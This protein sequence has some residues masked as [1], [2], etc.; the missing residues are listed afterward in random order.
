MSKRQA[1]K[2]FLTVDAIEMRRNEEVK[3]KKDRMR[4]LL[5]VA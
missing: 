3:N 5:Y 2:V 4:P 1:G